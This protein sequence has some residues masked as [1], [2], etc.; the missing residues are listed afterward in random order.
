MSTPSVQAT[1]SPTWVMRGMVKGAESLPLGWIRSSRRA[2]VARNSGERNCSCVRGWGEG[3]FGDFLDVA[4]AGAE[5]DDAVGE[6][7]RFVK[8]VGDEQDREVDVAPDFE[9]VALELAAGLRVERA[10]RIDFEFSAVDGL[11]TKIHVQREG[12]GLPITVALP[13]GPRHETAMLDSLLD[14]VSV[15]GKPGRPGQRFAVVAGDKGCEIPSA[16]LDRATR[17]HGG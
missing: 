7:D 5:D 16:S 3:D 6:V 11:S 2:L 14:D 13:P 8:V 9:P 12:R 15:A 17:F 10:E 1:S 4:G